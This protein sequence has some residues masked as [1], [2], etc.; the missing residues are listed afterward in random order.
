LRHR[1]KSQASAKHPREILLL[2]LTDLFP[3]K[4]ILTMQTTVTT[5]N[6]VTIP[7]EISRKMGITPGCR[8]QWQE[9]QQGSDELVV[10]VIPTRQELARRLKGR[11][12]AWAKGRNVV[13]ELIQE[14]MAEDRGEH[15]A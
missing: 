6:M 13:S 3:C 15:L 1:V 10:R 4:T 9:P 11:G 2:T 5:K 12:K 8:L 7:S 14:R